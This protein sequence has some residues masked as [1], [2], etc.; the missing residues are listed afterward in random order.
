MS[1]PLSGREVG[2]RLEI[3]VEPAQGFGEK[4]GKGA[5]PVPR[6]EFPKKMKLQVGM[7]IEIK[8][9]AGTPVKVWVTKVQGSQ[10]WIDLDHP[11][12][13]KELTFDVEILGIRDPMPSEL[14]HG[15]AHGPDGQHHH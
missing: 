7:P 12:A 3:R 11:L 15:H 8:D 4:Q 2:A 1:T 9:S 10:V 14:E 6:K 5:M 13:G